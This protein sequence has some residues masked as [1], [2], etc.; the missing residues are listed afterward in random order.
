[1]SDLTDHGA[2]GHDRLPVSD[3]DAF[4]D[5]IG[6]AALPLTGAVACLVDLPAEVAGP[7]ALRMAAPLGGPLADS[8]HRLVERQPG[9]PAPEDCPRHLEQEV[10]GRRLRFVVERLGGR[11]R[12][13]PQ[14]DLGT[15][16]L[17]FDAETASADDAGRASKGFLAMLEA[18]LVERR[19]KIAMSRDMAALRR[20]AQH[21]QRRVMQD[22]LTGLEN[23]DAF[24]QAVRRALN[25]GR[26]PHALVLLDVD[27]FKQINDLHGHQFGD[28][29]LRAI[30][31]ALTGSVPPGTRLGRIGGDE[32]ALLLRLQ[33]DAETVL[34]QVMRDCRAGLARMAQTIS[35]PGLGSVSMGVALFPRHS[36]SF[37]ALFEQADTALYAAKETG[38]GTDVIFDPHCHLRFSLR[39]LTR[40]FSGALAAGEIG[41]AFH[42]VVNLATGE[43]TGYEVLARWRGENGEVMGPELF[44]PIFDNAVLAQQLTCSMIRQATEVLRRLP[45]RGALGGAPLRMGINVTGFDLHNRQFSGSLSRLL[46]DLGLPWEAIVIEVPETVM[47]GETG[48]RAFETLRDLRKRGAAIALDD[49][50]TGYGSLRHLGTWPIDILKIDR[51]FVQ[52]L[53]GRP[54]D[55]AV[56]EAILGMARRFGLRVVA[57]GIETPGQLSYLQAMGCE[58]GQ[59]HLLSPPLCPGQLAGA[60]RVY[61]VGERVT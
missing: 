7:R 49:F 9:A 8:L 28:V 6:A 58:S 60:P 16:V 2:F 1:M 13:R 53:S 19:A 51:Q 56:V 20:H 11:H 25:A 47:L 44:Y 38:R 22:A 26:T 52:G 45:A 41:P 42:P 36:E 43:C 24:R 54:R 18:L 4:L 23:A 29:Y 48:G 14:P 35:K 12:P 33:D 61:P 57:E 10:A 31:G 5:R 32:F 21:L 46:S 3:L 59:G 30:A 15:L 39:E 27:H 37:E 34:S 50:G 17:G 40:N 55:R